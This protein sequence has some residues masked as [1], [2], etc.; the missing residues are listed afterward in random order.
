MLLLIGWLVG[1]ALSLALW[2]PGFVGLFV[3][4]GV[5]YKGVISPAWHT[6]WSFWWQFILYCLQLWIPQRIMT[7]LSIMLGPWLEKRPYLLLTV[8][9]FVSGVAYLAF[10]IWQFNNPPVIG[11]TLWII[12]ILSTA[13]VAQCSML[14]MR[15]LAEHEAREGEPP[16]WAG[17]LPEINSLYQFWRGFMKPVLAF[18][19][20]FD[21]RKKQKLKGNLGKAEAATPDELKEAGL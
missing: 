13:W 9:S 10:V 21:N 4:L 3:F 6:G 16:R 1:L 11:R 15:L 7:M 14:S 17:P 12:P 19:R 5:F 18:A 2:F 8:S 20:L